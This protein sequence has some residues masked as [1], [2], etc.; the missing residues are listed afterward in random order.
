MMCDSYCSHGG[1]CVRKRGHTGLHDAS[2]QCS[3]ADR[4]ALTREEADQVLART[5]QG[6]DYLGTFQPVADAFEDWLGGE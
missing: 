1:R 2:G 4:E 3:W 6:R 5:P